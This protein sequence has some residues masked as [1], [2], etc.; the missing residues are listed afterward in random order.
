MPRRKTGK[1]KVHTI[2]PDGDPRSMRSLLAA[3]LEWMAVRNY[4]QASVTGRA[5]KLQ[6]FL[7]W[8]QER[9]LS[10]P[11]EVTK[12]ILERYQR[13]LFHY[14]KKDGRPLGVSTQYHR[15]MTVRAW[16]RWLTKQNHLLYNPASELELPRQEKRLPAAVLTRAEAEAVLGQPDIR[17]TLGLRDRAI[18]EVLYSTGLRRKE[19]AALTAYNLDFERG[20]LMVRLGK[21][22]KDR[23][24]PIGERALAWVEKYL[25]DARPQLVVEPDPG[26]LFLTE[27]GEELHPDTLSSLV[28]QHVEASGIA[29]KGACHLFRHTMATLMLE[30]GADIRFIQAML[31]HA[32]L[33]STEVY[34][35]VS[36]QKLKGIHSATHPGARLGRARKPEEAGAGQAVDPRQQL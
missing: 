16:F 29:K 36:I 15:L 13:W 10:R 30:G 1:A 33:T 8:A 23:M 28:R 25:A 17:T 20:T 2:T 14:R 19:V 18:L 12:P 7:T 11:T 32:D 5:Q 35:R 26:H 9:G 34:T 3:Y 27:A 4:T 21:G 22:Q 6:V 31:G 24:V